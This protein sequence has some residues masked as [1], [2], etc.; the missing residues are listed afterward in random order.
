[1][2]SQ[3]AAIPFWLQLL[4]VALAPVMGFIGV[5]IG[6]ATQSRNARY[7]AIRDHRREVYTNF[8]ELLDSIDWTFSGPAEIAFEDGNRDEILRICSLIDN[9]ADQVSPMLV[10]IEFVGSKAT[11]AASREFLK[12][13]SL[14]HVA[15]GKGLEGH[16]SEEMWE[17]VKKKA[18]SARRAFRISAAKDLG[19]P[20]N[21]VSE[22]EI[23]DDPDYVALRDRLRDS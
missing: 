14:A 8:I 10:Q 15:I 16:Y 12:F 7:L 4:S 5:T 13:F 17:S 6:A 21:G 2:G 19:A 11:V 9:Y 18:H 20:K 23:T 22:S 3:Q 1:M